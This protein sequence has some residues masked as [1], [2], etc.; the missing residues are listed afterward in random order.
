M[1][2]N[3]NVSGSEKSPKDRGLIRKHA[4][5]LPSRPAGENRY[6]MSTHVQSQLGLTCAF[7]GT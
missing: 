5:S 1:S 2:M 6:S 7:G 4:C 3:D